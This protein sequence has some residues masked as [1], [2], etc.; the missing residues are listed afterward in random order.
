[1]PDDLLTAIRQRFGTGNPAPT[2]DLGDNSSSLQDA[3]RARFGTRSQVP[4]MEK[5]GG[6]PP[7]A[8]LPPAYTDSSGQVHKNF[9]AR[10]L[11]AL[12]DPLNAPPGDISP[13]AD[14]NLGQRIAAKLPINPV[15]G[16]ENVVQGVE[17]AASPGHV[18]EGINKIL[19][20]G[21]EAASPG[22]P[23]ALLKAPIATIGGLATGGA[24]DWAGNKAAQFLG[25]PPEWAGAIGHGLGILGGGFIGGRIAKNS[26]RP[27]RPVAEDKPPTGVSHSQPSPAPEVAPP[28][29]PTDQPPPLPPWADLIPGTPKSAQES[30]EVLM[31]RALPRK[32]A[33]ESAEVLANAPDLPEPP[34]VPPGVIRQPSGITNISQAESDYGP[35]AGVIP[36]RVV[37]LTPYQQRLRGELG[38]YA[39]L[40]PSRIT[41]PGR[42]GPEP[43]LGP[44]GPPPP[45]PIPPEVFGSTDVTPRSALDVP[46]EPQAP[47]QAPPEPPPSGP[48]SPDDIPDLPIAPTPGKPMPGKPGLWDQLTF[49][50]RQRFGYRHPGDISRARANTFGS[51]DMMLSEFRDTKPIVD[52]VHQGFDDEARWVAETERRAAPLVEGLDATQHQ[53]IGEMLDTAQ[54]PMDLV[55]KVSPRFKLP[56]TP[57][58]AQRATG[59]RNLFDEIIAETEQARNV[60]AKPGE[61]TKFGR[62]A[63]YV[64][65][66]LKLNNGEYSDDLTGNLHSL[67]DE[68]YGRPLKAVGDELLGRSMDD[69]LNEPEP[70]STDTEVAMQPKTQVGDPSSPFVRAR[71]GALTNYDLNIN[72]LLPAYIES[73]A[74]LR[75]RQ[76]I[77]EQAKAMID[78]LPEGSRK[79]LAISYLRQYTGI[80]N[81][82]ISA[83]TDNKAVNALTSMASRLAL[84]AN[85]QVLKYHLG[86]LATQVW[87]NLGTKYSSLGL[88]A[89]LRNPSDVINEINALGIVPQNVRPWQFK[90]PSE[91]LNDVG[92]FLHAAYLLDRG[93]AFKGFQAKALDMGMEPTQAT[94]WA[95]TQTKNAS[96]IPD[97][98]RS[99]YLAKSGGILGKLKSTWSQIPARTLEQFYMIAKHASEDPEKVNI[100]GYG[101]VSA[102]LV[103][104]VTALGGLGGITAATGQK[105]THISASVFSGTMPV[106][107]YIG[108]T[109]LH[110]ASGNVQKALEDVV[111]KSGPGKLV[112]EIGQDIAGAKAAIDNLSQ[113]KKADEY[114]KQNGNILGTDRAKRLLDPQSFG[115]Q[116]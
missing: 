60:N 59:V 56:Y 80:E 9:K 99:T 45:Q 30:A 13:L 75:F 5:L 86:Q 31:G 84:T 62:I 70:Q 100:P 109:I 55:G 88:Q 65:R 27:V 64:N 82:S 2:D 89:F 35:A 38:P 83:R 7:A 26:S 39:D 74:R 21:L 20:G 23:G 33:A 66:M 79:E 6:T 47:S 42:P 85:P 14:D 76:P 43:E 102:K 114:L 37:G 81:A 24:L 93:V 12:T 116:Q 115:P 111:T 105:F 4:G 69:Y 49:P 50:L 101:P 68:F 78:K 34:T 46:P 1:M 51:P 28:P 95:I 22:L 44:P 3:I 91:K 108:R 15:R 73:M 63:N 71:T 61:E 104:L 58:L 54:N 113:D 40:L 110:L 29:P 107:D 36:D 25:A 32:S 94:R 103:R 57:D 19:G 96:A 72:N 52:T 17:A 112:N 87:V 97:T 77:A 8:G 67:W 11:A 18:G 53:M 106:A 48:V 16:I 98:V 90:T 41:E 10:P 92:D